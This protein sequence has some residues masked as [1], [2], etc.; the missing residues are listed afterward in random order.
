MLGTGGE[1]IKNIIEKRGRCKTNFS[2]EAEGTQGCYLVTVNRKT[3]RLALRGM[4]NV[5]H[6]TG[7]AV[8][9]WFMS[10]ARAWLTSIYLLSFDNQILWNI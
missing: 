10:N 6:V 1:N 4:A 2:Q 3:T 7:S 9:S 8:L 5:W